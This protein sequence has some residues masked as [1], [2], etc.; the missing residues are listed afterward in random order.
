[1]RVSYWNSIFPDKLRCRCIRT[2]LTA[3]TLTRASG[4]KRDQGR[5]NKDI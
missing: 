4:F 3:V 2:V 5:D 1:M